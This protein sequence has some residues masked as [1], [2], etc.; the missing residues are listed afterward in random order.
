MVFKENKGCNSKRFPTDFSLRALILTIQVTY[1]IVDV[2]GQLGTYIK[3]KRVVDLVH[4]KNSKYLR[5]N[6]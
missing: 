3:G 2:V 4:S 5:I 1:D 6:V